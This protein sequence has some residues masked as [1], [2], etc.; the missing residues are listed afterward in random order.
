MCKCVHWLGAGD[1]TDIQIKHDPAD[2]WS[3]YH[4]DMVQTC[5]ASVDVSLS[6]NGM[7]ILLFLCHFFMMQRNLEAMANSSSIS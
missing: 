7:S 1:S 3:T 5:L 2:S 4:V 6:G